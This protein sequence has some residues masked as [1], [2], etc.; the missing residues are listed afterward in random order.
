MNSYLKKKQ[1]T[2]ISCLKKHN[3][4]F[5]DRVG[6]DAIKEQFNDTNKSYSK[7]EQINGLAQIITE[8]PSVLVDLRSE[9][10]E[11]KTNEDGENT[12]LD[13]SDDSSS[14]E[15]GESAPKPSDGTITEEGIAPKSEV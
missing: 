13:S 10:D 8:T 4:D 2:I 7:N 6:E 14:G 5:Y 1:S 12:T 11:K 9:A 15:E 3:K